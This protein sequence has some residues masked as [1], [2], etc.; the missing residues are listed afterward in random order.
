MDREERE[1]LKKE[2]E[3]LRYEY[4]EKNLGDFTSVYPVKD[5]EEMLQYDKYMKHARTA[6]EDFTGASNSRKRAEQNAADEKAA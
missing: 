3:I 1:K 5:E 4:E 2:R 6:W